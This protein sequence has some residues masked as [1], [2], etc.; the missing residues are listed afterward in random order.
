MIMAGARVPERW[1]NLWRLVGRDDLADNPDYLA[2]GDGE[3]IHDQV[4]PALEEWSQQRPK[5]E[6]AGKF[7]ELGFSMG[8]AQTIEDLA[9]CPQLA[10]RDMFVETGDTAGGRF[11]SLRTPLRLLGCA[12]IEPETAPLLGQD[13]REVLCKL[14]GLTEADLAALEAE[15]AV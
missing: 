13:N 10:A 4:I 9:H 1:R 2:P 8:V 15:G 7:T 6:V 5:W 14:G 12:N 11:R 3:F